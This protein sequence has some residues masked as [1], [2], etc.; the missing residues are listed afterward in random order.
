MTRLAGVRDQPA[1]VVSDY[2]TVR[3]DRL[4][5][6]NRSADE[7]M[8]G[9]AD[10]WAEAV[11]VEEHVAGQ[12]IARRHVDQGEI[13]VVANRDAALARDSK[14]LGGV[15]GQKPPDLRKRQARPARKQDRERRLH[16]GDAAPDGKCI[17]ALFH[18]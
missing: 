3:E 11:A 8:E 16:A 9:A 15:C 2:F 10:V 14:A 7:A 12:F 6:S 13:C 5:A 4:P 17:V 18:W 1:A